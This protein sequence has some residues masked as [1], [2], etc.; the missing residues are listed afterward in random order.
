M[1]NSTIKLIPHLLLCYDKTPSSKRILDYLKTVFKGVKLELTLLQ[2][3]TLPEDLLYPQTDILK[4]LKREAQLEEILKT[5]FEKTEIELKKI[6]ETLQKD[7]IAKP[8]AKPVI[9]Q[10]DLGETILRYSKEDLYD[11][12]IIGRRGL[13][14]IGSLVM[15]SVSYKLLHLSEIPVWIVRGEAWNQKFLVALDTEEMGIK[16][17][18]YVTFILKNHPFAEIKFLHITSPFTKLEIEE[19]NLETLVKKACGNESY[20]R[21]FLSL[22]N[23]VTENQFDP[24]RIKFKVKRALF[25]P[26]GDIIRE[27]KKENYGTVIVGKRKKRGLKSLI[28]GS[29]SHKIVNYFAD[30][31]VWVIS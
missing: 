31:T 14:K 9:K 8:L 13:S 21:F 19:E 7:F 16:V 26:A 5:I 23:V 29:V 17:A 12:I 6:A 1:E 30:R 20:Q 28:L 25:G 22:Y 2:V 11:G 3:V 27:V 24:E 10:G 4:E 18:D 15:G